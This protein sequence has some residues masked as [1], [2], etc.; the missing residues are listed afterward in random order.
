MFPRP[1]Q[2]AAH[3]AG[4]SACIV[5]MALTPLPSVGS[6]TAKATRA[7]LAGTLNADD[8]AKLHLVHTS[9]STLFEEGHA[10]GALPGNMRAQLRVGAMFTGSFTLY[11][12]HGQLKGRGSATPHGAGRIQSFGGTV[13][14]TGG[15]GRYAHAHGS[16]G[17]YGTF[18]RRTYEVVLQTRGPFKD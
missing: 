15:T 7:Y 9:G 16:G 18:N 5:G 11:T 12:A 1:V 4:S 13:V 14:V 2:V 3:L 10:S 8:T 6:A 17:L